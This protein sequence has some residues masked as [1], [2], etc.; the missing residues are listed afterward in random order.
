MMRPL[1]AMTGSA[2]LALVAGGTGAQADTYN[3]VIGAGHPNTQS[4]V[5]LLETV[6]IPEVD[7]RLAEAGKGDTINWT[8]AWGGS[9]VQFA[10]L[11]EGVQ[12]GLLDITVSPNV[13]RPSELPMNMVTYMTP[14]GTD[15]IETILDIVHEM[16]VEFPEVAEQWAAYNQEALGHYIYSSHHI[17]GTFPIENFADMEGRKVGAA[18][19]VGNF[20]QN[21]GA[22]AA[23]GN[24]TTYYNDI[25]TG[26]TEG[27]TGPVPGMYQAKLFEVADHLNLVNFGGQYVLSLTMNSDTLAGL[28]AYMQDIF[29]EA[30]RAWEAALT[31]REKA[32]AAK[33]IA[34]FEAAGVEVHVLSD[35]E[36]AKWAAALPDLAGEWV[37]RLEA[38]GKPGK[39][40]LSFYMDALRE[41]GVTPARD[42]DAGIE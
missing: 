18:G 39:E 26:V 30:G 3:I 11:L 22:A 13:I 15:D 5:E 7:K 16:Y 27:G 36:R 14:F 10:S 6:F 33:A 12:S 35:E 41:R 2:L 23:N 42:W 4:F 29:R 9:I 20:F 1:H 40:L 8:R 24:F 34:D 28:P 25:Q 38:E 19:V 31:E 37:E 17:I 32:D 21:T